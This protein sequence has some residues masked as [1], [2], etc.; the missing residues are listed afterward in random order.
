MRK[1]S[2]KEQPGRSERGEGESEHSKKAEQT[3]KKKSGEEGR[4]IKCNV[5]VASLIVLVPKSRDA[6][7]R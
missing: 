3:G 1:K 6:M 4:E 7:T 2:L 5:S